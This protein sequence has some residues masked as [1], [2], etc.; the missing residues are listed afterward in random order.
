MAMEIFL[1]MPLENLFAEGK[2]K[3]SGWVQTAREVLLKGLLSTVD[4]LLLTS[5]EQLIFLIGNIIKS[6]LTKQAVLTRRS[7]V[8][9][10]SSQ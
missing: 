7:T 2:Y 9:S 5:L 3:Y 1:D 6:F 4:L 10:L 8:L